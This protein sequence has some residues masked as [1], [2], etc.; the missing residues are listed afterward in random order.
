MSNVKLLRGQVRQIVKELLPEV[1]KD[2]VIRAI[3]AQCIERIE[4]IEKF[5]KATLN[6]MSKRHRD[7][8]LSLMRQ[9]SIPAEKDP[10]EKV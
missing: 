2:E 10:N 1:L 7:T 3:Q 9:A 6:D 4:E 8:M 5:T